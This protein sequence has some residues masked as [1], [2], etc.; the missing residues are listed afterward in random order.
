MA[1]FSGRRF[2]L[3]AVAAALALACA[4]M[5][6]QAKREARQQTFCS[7]TNISAFIEQN[8]TS[9]DDAT[10]ERFKKVVDL[11]AFY[12]A[13]KKNK[14]LSLYARSASP[15][16]GTDALIKHWNEKYHLNDHRML[17]Y[18]LAS[19]WHETGRRMSPVRE[20]F[21]KS[22]AAVIAYLDRNRKPSWH[23]YWY[24]VKETG[25]AYFGRGQIQLTWADNY[26]KADRL[27]E[28]E[29]DKSIYWNPDLALE[30]NQSSE[31]TFDGMM[32]GWFRP[33]WCLPVF[34]K[35]SRTPNWNGARD[36][37]NGDYSKNGAAIGNY[38][39]AFNAV[40][41]SPG[42]ITTAAALEKKQKVD[43]EQER[44]AEAERLR[45]EQEAADEAERLAAAA[46]EEA[47]RKAAE[48][49]ARAAE[50]A[51]QQA[52]EEALAKEAEELAQAR[53]ADNAA[54]R[55]SKIEKDLLALR[56]ELDERDKTAAENVDA[57]VTGL[58]TIERDLS[59]RITLQG[60]SVE[61][62][63]DDL[64]S[65]RS[66]S[67]TQSQSLKRL[68]SDMATLNASVEAINRET[69][70]RL[71]ADMAALKDSIDV[72]RSALMKD[73]NDRNLEVQR[74]SRKVELMEQCGFWS[75][76]FGCDT[77]E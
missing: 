57:I 69:V 68:S 50:L 46:R 9:I 7:R 60:Q 67:E 62:L 73:L 22:D 58:E 20:G 72:M 23:Y 45:K 2:A 33:G 26:K 17:A 31:I 13:A 37:V 15:Y 66:T 56:Q 5:E 54:E 77:G 34:F 18:V 16:P 8:N 11:E 21:G 24:I 38:A 43:E 3:G 49:A 59:S 32:Y 52:K 39:K 65:L 27:L 1:T 55:M 61:R 75:N 74:L 51:E 10:G 47:A 76:I 14:T 53:A 36:I 19:V 28:Y 6:A 70:E 30:D 4:P 41:E 12:N 64:A 42:V 29:R 35:P 25:K 71:S 40:L 44:L 48:E 63:S